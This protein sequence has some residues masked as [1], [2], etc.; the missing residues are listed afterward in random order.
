MNSSGELDQAFSRIV[1]VYQARLDAV[2]QAHQV[3]VDGLKPGELEAFE[4]INKIEEQLHALY[5][6]EL[7]DGHCVAEENRP[8][9]SRLGKERDAQDALISEETWATAE[10]YTDAVYRLQDEGEDLDN[11]IPFREFSW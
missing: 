11:G 3:F 2:R 5:Q 8:E 10:K 7:E 1:G 4:A 9:S 6:G